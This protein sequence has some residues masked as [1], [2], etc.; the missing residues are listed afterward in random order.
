MP[1]ATV[2]NKRE[3][4]FNLKYNRADFSRAGNYQ[5]KLMFMY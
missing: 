5:I 4:A 2:G 3:Q 1:F